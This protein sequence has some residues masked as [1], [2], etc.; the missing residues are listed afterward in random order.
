MKFSG[1]LTKQRG[2]A[3]VEISVVLLAAMLLSLALVDLAQP[4][5]QQ[6]R[7][8][9]LSED[10]VW[11]VSAQR[12]AEE[13]ITID[14]DQYKN[15]VAELWPTSERSETG[16]PDISVTRLQNGEAPLT[17]GDCGS[18]IEASKLQNLLAPLPEGQRPAVWIVTVCLAQQDG[19]AARWFDTGG[20]G[21]KAFPTLTARSVLVERHGF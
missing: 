11:L 8:Q 17:D 21:E 20:S 6:Q 4:G 14:I 10:I 9:Q 15:L 12:K 2:V 18:E 13:T 5:Y 1:W 16:P 7:L 3:E 19:L